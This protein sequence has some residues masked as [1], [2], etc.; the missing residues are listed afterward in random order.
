M[1]IEVGKYSSDAVQTEHSSRVCAH[2]IET[3]QNLPLFL[4]YTLFFVMM[5]KGDSKTVTQA[6]E[7]GAIGLL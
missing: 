1:M 2:S 5:E 7:G 4:D 3:Y 6:E